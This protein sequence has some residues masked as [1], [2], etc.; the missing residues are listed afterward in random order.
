MDSTY[1]SYEYNDAVHEHYV[2]LHFQGCTFGDN[3]ATRN[4]AWFAVFSQK[5][6]QKG[7]PNFKFDIKEGQLEG[8]VFDHAYLY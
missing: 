3:P 1:Y 5:K 8:E 7:D 6:E 2:I 4:A